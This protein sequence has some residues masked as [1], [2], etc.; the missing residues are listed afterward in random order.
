MQKIMRKNFISLFIALVVSIIP[1]ISFASVYGDGYVL[2]QMVIFSRHGVRSPLYGA[3]SFAVRS[4]P[5]K[6][7]NWSAKPGELTL[8]GGAAETLLGEYFRLW[9]EDEKFIP[10]NYIPKEGEIRVYTNSHQRTISTAR[11]FTAGFIPM[12]NVKIEY[13][14]KINETDPAFLPNVAFTPALRKVTEKEMA[15]GTGLKNYLASLQND[16][17]K[18]MEVLDYKNSVAGAKN[19]IIKSDDITIKMEKGISINGMIRELHRAADAL[20]LQYYEDADDLRAAFNHRLSYSDWQAIGRVAYF[21][22]DALAFVPTYDAVY[23][24][25]LLKEMSAELNNPNRKIAL[26]CGHDSNI[27]TILP[28]LGVED[29][30]LNQSIPPKTPLGGKI[31]ISRLNGA[32]GNEYVDLR[33]IY[34]G[35]QDMRNLTPLTLEHPAQMKQLRLKGLTANKDGYYKLEDMNK[36]FAD[37]IAIYGKYMGRN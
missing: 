34:S 22:L 1:A 11:F 20:T 35:V 32:D 31:V 5:H 12:G 26:F 15:S 4:T 28:A 29:Y 9:L 6:W 17:N 8:K 3:D 16:C 7:I 10:H 27:A 25:P 30:A 21:T 19:P 2:K 14:Y 24:H 37:A 13:K 33:L 23:A 36:R 18:V